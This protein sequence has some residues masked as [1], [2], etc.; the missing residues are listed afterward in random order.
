MVQAVGHKG[1]VPVGIHHGLVLIIL[2]GIHGVAVAVLV[3]V[4]L[5]LGIAELAPGHEHH[6]L[7]PIHA[8]AFWGLGVVLRVDLGVGV[9]EAGGRMLV[10]FL[11]ADQHLAIALVGV[12]VDGIARVDLVVRF[13]FGGFFFGFRVG[14]G[15]RFLGRIALLRAVFVHVVQSGAVIRFLR[16][17]LFLAADQN[18]FEGIAVV[19]V[20]M[21]GAEQFAGL[22]VVAIILM[23]VVALDAAGQ[24]LFFLVAI[25]GVVVQ[26][27]FRLRLF[28][29]DGLTFRLAPG[30]VPVRSAGV[31]VPCA[32]SRI[33]RFFDDFS[34]FIAAEW[35]GALDVAIVGMLVFFLP[36]VI[37]RVIGG[38]RDAILMQPPADAHGG[39][40][41]QHQNH[42]HRTP[43]QMT[44]PLD[45]LNG[46]LEA[47]LHSHN[48]FLSSVNQRKTGQGPDA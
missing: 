7:G 2:V 30:F 37:A 23:D 45:V 34:L 21:L 48:G 46:F 40:H 18:L 24:H 8:G 47:I 41:R 39:Q 13:G 26:H 32:I 20:L 17:A 33:H 29:R 12:V 19:G 15:L 42:C 9:D 14:Y 3:H 35:L 31:T 5:A 1:A 36:A 44:L 11:A 4:G 22:L 10:L 28:L 27:H 6:V 43:G 25:R 38:K 16:L